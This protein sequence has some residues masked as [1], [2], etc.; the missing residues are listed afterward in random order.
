[1]RINRFLQRK[2]RVRARVR[3]TK[4]RPRLSVFRSNKGIYAQIIDDT[5]GSTLVSVAST[6][7]KAPKG[8]SKS[9]M[10]LFVGQTLAKKALTKK[11]KKVVFD[12]GGYKYHGRIKVLADAARKEGLEF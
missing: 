2:L 7:A 9:D 12:K 3:G 10:S 1:M 4:A 5:N 6:E 8:T 11:L